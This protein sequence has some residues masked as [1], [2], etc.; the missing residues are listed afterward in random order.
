MPGKKEKKRKYI[1]LEAG[2]RNAG[3]NFDQH[4]KGWGDGSVG[5]LC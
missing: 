1:V 4:T 5:K 3:N 2:K